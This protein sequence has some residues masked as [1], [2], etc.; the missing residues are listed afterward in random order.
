MP[1]YNASSIIQAKEVTNIPKVGVVAAELSDRV[2]TE[3][4][5]RL[6]QL[7]SSWG[8]FEWKGN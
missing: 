4:N 3:E 6:V 5:H 1:T 8:T 2:R 7:R